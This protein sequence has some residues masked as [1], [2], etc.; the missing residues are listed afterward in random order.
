MKLVRISAKNFRS[1]SAVD[2]PLVDG[3]NALVG[4]NNCGKSNLV[5]A[6]RMA[7]DPDYPFQ[8]ERDVPGQ[9]R[10]AFP[11]VALTFSLDRT[12]GREKTLMRY[13]AEY[14]SSALG[15]GRATYA[16]DG[17]ARLVVT[18]RGQ[19]RSGLTRQ[20][21]FAARGAGDRRGGYEPE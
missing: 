4:P 12:N 20:E 19:Q 5:E 7:L 8:A 17:T 21:F 13:L 1:L 16:E 3:M 14:E 11:R 2:F 6:V 10:Y 15:E 9:M 18:Y